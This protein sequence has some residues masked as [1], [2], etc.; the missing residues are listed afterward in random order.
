MKPIEYIRSGI[1]RHFFLVCLGVWSLGYW[2]IV[3]DMKEDYRQ[4]VLLYSDLKK[5]FEQKHNQSVNIDAY[6]RQIQEMQSELSTLDKKLPSRLSLSNILGNIEQW[7]ETRNIDVV[8]LKVNN[9]R[10]EEFYLEHGLTIDLL[11]SFSD[12][13]DLI[14][15]LNSPDNNISRIH[16]F[17]IE[18]IPGDFRLRARLNL[19]YFSY[20][21]ESEH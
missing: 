21:D 16:K 20:R 19:S 18:K 14:N 6:A 2:L 13:V 7:T 17:S 3:A 5:S 12:F 11:L 8:E 4:F 15:Y 9:T 10:T 1:V